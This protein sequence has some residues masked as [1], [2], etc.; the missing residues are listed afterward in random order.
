MTSVMRMCDF[1]LLLLQHVVGTV[2]LNNERTDAVAVEVV[3]H[4][5]FLKV[6]RQAQVL[7]TDFS[8]N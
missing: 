1:L 2:L 8:F 6:V 4:S 5:L 3:L 7:L